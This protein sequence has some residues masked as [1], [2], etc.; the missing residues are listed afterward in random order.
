MGTY[1]DAL[2]QYNGYAV[3]VR[4]ESG[5]GGYADDSG[6]GFGIARGDGIDVGD[7]RCDG[8]ELIDGRSSDADG[9]G[10]GACDGDGGRGIGGR[11]GL[12]RRQCAADRDDPV[13]E[14]RERVGSGTDLPVVPSPAGVA[15]WLGSGSIESS[16]G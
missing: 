5:G 6:T 1:A 11:D 7:E 9:G 10:G 13:V 4:G 14:S 8:G 16:M 15:D 2:S 3:W 12:G